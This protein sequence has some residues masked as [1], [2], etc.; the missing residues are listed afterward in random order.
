MVALRRGPHQH[1]Q[2]DQRQRH[3][4]RREDADGDMSGAPAELLDAVVHQWR[5]DHAADVIAAGGDGDREPAVAVEPV[6]GLRHQRPESGRRRQPDR[7]MHE[8]ELPDRGRHARDDIAESQ[9]A[10]AEPD[11]G[12]DAVAVGDLAGQ[13]AAGTEAEH[14]KCKRQRGGA[15]AGGKLALHRRQRHHHRPHSDAAERADQHGD[16]KPNPRPAR[17]GNKQVGISDEL[18]RNCHGGRNFEGQ[19]PKVKPHCRDIG[20]ADVTG[21]APPYL[22]GISH[23]L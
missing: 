1:P 16:G 12:D 19:S 4:H 17:V 6:R 18:G 23:R 7:E 13:H 22:G 21:Q 14:Q 5:P 11:R 2:D 3:R 15:A 8:D 9:N 20:H 10:D